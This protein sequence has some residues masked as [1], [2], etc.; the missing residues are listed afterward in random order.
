MKNIASLRQQMG[1]TLIEAIIVILITAVV[2]GMVAM[3]IRMPFLAYIDVAAR[4]ELTDA[5]ETA[6]RRIAR[7]V[8]LALPNS[9]RI[10]NKTPTEPYLEL[11]LTKTGGRYLDE[12]DGITGNYLQFERPSLNCALTPLDAGCSFDVL[13]NMPSA[14]LNIVAGDQLIVYNLGIEQAD[15]YVGGNRTTINTVVGNRLTMSN[16]VFALQSPAMRSP[17]RRFQIV[18]TPVTYFCEPPD[19]DI[20]GKLWR[21]WDYPITAVQA[22][23]PVGGKRAL[24]ADGILECKFDYTNIANLH[25]ALVNVFFKME[26]PK[27]DTGVVTLF[28]QIHVDNTP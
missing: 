12:D 4:A 5:A 20:T 17:T 11:L 27:G 10:T 13:G 28:S 16:Q 2:A 25:S 21:Y 3:F 19:K 24:L 14:P 9:V 1:F 23:P 8:R 18:S 6:T 7:D 26:R 15:A 22:T